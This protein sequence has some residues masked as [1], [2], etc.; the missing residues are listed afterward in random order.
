[1]KKNN[2]T[3]EDFK[4]RLLQIANHYQVIGIYCTVCLI[5][6]STI[7]YLTRLGTEVAGCNMHL[8]QVHNKYRYATKQDW[9]NWFE[10]NILYCYF[11]PRLN[12][13]RQFPDLLYMIFF[14]MCCFLIV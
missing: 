9:N 10:K 3:V 14:L 13:L 5:A 1:M 8:L 7:R 6:Y 11:F 2:G 4:R 12:S